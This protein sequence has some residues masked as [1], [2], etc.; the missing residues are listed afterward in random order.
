MRQIRMTFMSIFMKSVGGEIKLHLY[1][2][3]TKVS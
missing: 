3:P 1:L 2:S